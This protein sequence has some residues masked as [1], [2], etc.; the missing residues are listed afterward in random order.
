[1]NKPYKELKSIL[2]VLRNNDNELPLTFTE[3]NADKL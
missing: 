1:M 3:F 2:D